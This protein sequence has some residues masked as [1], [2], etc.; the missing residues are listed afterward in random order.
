VGHALDAAGVLVGFVVAAALAGAVVDA[1]AEGGGVE[2]G[3]PGDCVGADRLDVH[4]AAPTATATTPI[5]HRPR[6]PRG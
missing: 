3:F 1:P 5:H 4:A 6:P 2:V